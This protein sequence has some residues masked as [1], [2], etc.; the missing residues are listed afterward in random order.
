[1]NEQI[2][3]VVTTYGWVLDEGSL[4]RTAYIAAAGRCMYRAI[5][6]EH[7]STQN[8]C[9]DS[10]LK[11]LLSDATLIQASPLSGIIPSTVV[12]SRYDRMINDRTNTTF[13]A[14]I[15]R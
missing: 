3:I 13:A 1:M 12:G 5:A 4:V 14:R 2:L 8:K 9:Q 10:R 15:Y 11:H 6:L 7:G